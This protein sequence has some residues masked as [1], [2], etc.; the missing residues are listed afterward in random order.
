MV[1]RDR[2]LFPLM[3]VAAIAF[4]ML[5]VAGIAA[6]SGWLAFGSEGS[7]Q[8]DRFAVSRA[9]LMSPPGFVRAAFADDPGNATTPT[10]ADCSQMSEANDRRLYSCTRIR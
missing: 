6:I 5:S 1:R 9:D 10:F 7:P 3:V 2:L 4:V 8:G